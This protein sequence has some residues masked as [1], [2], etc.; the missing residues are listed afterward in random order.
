[1]GN[2][3]IP[4]KHVINFQARKNYD[5]ETYLLGFMVPEDSSNSSKKTAQKWA[6][7]GNLAANKLNN[8]S[9]L[10]PN[11]PVKNV[12]I[13]SVVSRWST[14]NKV[15]R[16][17]DP[18]ADFQLEVYSGNL[19]HIIQNATI[20]NGVIQEECIWGRDSNG[21]NYLLVKGTDL[22]KNAR[23]YSDVRDTR[24]SLRDVNR[25]DVV[26]IHDGRTIKYYGGFYLAEGINNYGHG[27][28]PKR[29]YVF[30]VLD[31]GSRSR[32]G[33]GEFDTKS[34]LKV[35]EIVEESDPKLSKTEAE[36]VVNQALLDGKFGHRVK[37]NFFCASKW[38]ADDVEISLA[39]Q[40]D[41][42][43]E[44]NDVCK[45]FW[46]TDNG[47][48]L[49]Y[50]KYTQKKSKEDWTGIKIKKD[51]L[52]A[53]RHITKSAKSI[54]GRQRDEDITQPYDGEDLYVMQAKIGSQTF[55]VT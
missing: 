55:N 14:S 42:N 5:G 39:P 31:S 36:E 3:K 23:E 1:M 21:N 28:T 37:A 9:F 2:I 18:R 41:T 25:G 26:K 32:W 29:H 12:E 53:I 17:K 35:G 33:E 22:Y 20:K 45:R 7:R 38:D 19:N 30:E 24:I 4:K 48:H 50:T 15:W 52:V 34:S 6:N 16:V 13:M 8:K 11:K 47:K 43:V 54:Y 10:I 40:E 51:P 49:Y 46:Y 44:E 27:P